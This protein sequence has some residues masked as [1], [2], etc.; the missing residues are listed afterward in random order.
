M[1]NLNSGEQLF[2]I[3]LT[4]SFAVSL[5]YNILPYIKQITALY[6]LKMRL[7]IEKIVIEYLKTLSKD[8]N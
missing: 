8:D 2:I 3:T 6:R 5:Y 1:T 4:V 7:Y